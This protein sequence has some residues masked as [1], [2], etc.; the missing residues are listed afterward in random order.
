M[1]K[2]KVFQYLEGSGGPRGVGA[3]PVKEIVEEGELQL[4]FPGLYSKMWPL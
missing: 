4:R 2:E 3:V 1:E